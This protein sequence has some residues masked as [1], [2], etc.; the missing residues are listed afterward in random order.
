MANSVKVS[1]IKHKNNKK[2]NKNMTNNNNLKAIVENKKPVE[3]VYELKDEY[4][5]PSFEEFMKTYGSDGNLNYDDLNSGDIG[6]PKVYGPGNG[7]KKGKGKEYGEQHL[8]DTFNKKWGKNADGSW[9]GSLVDK[10]EGG[11]LNLTASQRVSGGVGGALYGSEASLSVFK[12]DFDEGGDVRLISGTLGSEI[13]GGGL[14]GNTI[15]YMASLDA[16]RASS[17]GVS[18]NIGLDGGSKITAG[19][20][21]V[22]V[23]V[24]GFGGSI[25]KKIGF[26]TPI[27][28]ASVDLEEACVVQ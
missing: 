19:P 7:D 14:G 4:K 28:G 26:S 16:V 21:G 18:A 11:F 2:F 24:A 22:E 15:G 13:G 20:G 6:T 17:N 9:D 8:I 12:H 1:K 23:K 25:G 10:A 3:T 5:I 27:G